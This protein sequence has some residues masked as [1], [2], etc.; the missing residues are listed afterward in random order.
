MTNSTQK[1]FIL[2]IWTSSATK[3]D[4]IVRPHF[5]RFVINSKQHL[6]LVFSPIVS[7][8]TVWCN[9]TVVLIRLQ[10]GRIPV[11]FY[12]RDPISIYLIT[13]Q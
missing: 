11:L 7:L 1:M 2:V 13:N 5:Q 4:K 12:Q 8:K 6:C 10:L 3:T 9:Y